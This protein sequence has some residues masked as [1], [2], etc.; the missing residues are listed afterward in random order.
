MS[1]IKISL[2]SPGFTPVDN[3]FIDNYLK[4]IRGDFLKVYL[5]CLR[6]GF[7]ER[8]V[9]ISYIASKLCMLDTDVYRALEELNKMG[10]LTIENPGHIE[11]NSLKEKRNDEILF[12]E[13]LR[14]MLL[15]LERN[16][17]RPLSFRDIDVFKSIL[18]DY[19]LCPEVITMLVEYCISKNKPD[20]R[21][22]EKVAQNWHEAGVKTPEDAGNLISEYDKKWVKYK[23]ILKFLG[24]TGSDVTKPQEDMFNKWLYVYK[25][26]TEVIQKACEICILKTNSTNLNYIDKILQD[27]HKKGVKT[28]EDTIQNKQPYSPAYKPVKNKDE[29]GYDVSK[30]R[31]QLLGLGDE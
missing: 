13:N 10:V 22:M 24:K 7:A 5:F 14:D 30:I 16:L 11:I 25:F 18:S 23:E 27:W 15:E 20:I 2:K 8:D 6:Q 4:D 3:T 9:N 12:D 21:Y 31:K 17:G 26:P 1:N 29:Y 28:V 19:N